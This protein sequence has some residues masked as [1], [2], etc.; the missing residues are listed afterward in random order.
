MN[1][2]PGD[3]ARI[4]GPSTS[5]NRDRIV[6]CIRLLA[7]GEEMVLDG[8]S[9]LAASHGEFWAVEGRLVGENP[10]GR[11]VIVNGGPIGDQWLRPIRDPGDDAV[12][13]TLQRLPAPSRDEVMV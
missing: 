11:M 7:R 9:F 13:E 2:K 3:L 5:P 1:C 10:M 6:R 12:D 8:I 4:I